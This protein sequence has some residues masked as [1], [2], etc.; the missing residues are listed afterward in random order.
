MKK[1]LSLCLALC[2]AFTLAA[3]ALA[4]TVLAEAPLTAAE[5]PLPAGAPADDGTACLPEQVGS[6]K[7][8]QLEAVYLNGY[9]GSDSKD[10]TTAAQAVRTLDKALSLLA[11]NGTVYICGTVGL[12]A[13]KTL[14]NIRFARESTYKGSLFSVAGKGSVL[15]LN[16]V[17][18]DG[19]NVQGVTDSLVSVT[20]YGTL[21]VNEGTKLINNYSTGDGGA[22]YAYQG[23]LSLNGGEISNN[24]TD[25]AGGG[26]GAIDST[27][28][29]TGT[30]ITGNTSARRGGGVY[31]EKYSPTAQ[32]VFTISAGEISGNRLT[33]EGYDGAGICIWKD[34]EVRISGGTIKDNTSVDEADAA[35]T[36][37]SLNGG[38]TSFATLKLSGSPVI[39]GDVCLWDEKTAGPVI[40]VDGTFVPANPV[41]V[42]ANWWS[43]GTV[44]A[45]YDAGSTPDPA[46]FEPMDEEYGL[47]VDGQTL[48]WVEK[49]RVVFK[50]A[51][52]RTTYKRLYVMPNTLVDKSEAPQPDAQPG[53]YLMGWVRYGAQTLWD[54]DKNP[55]VDKSTSLLAA[56]GIK[57]PE[58][59]I[60]KADSTT[61]YEGGSVVLT[62]SATQENPHATF[63][64][65]WYQDGQQIP[66]ADGQ[67]L[68][69]TEPGSYMVKVQAMLN[70]RL[71]EQ[72]E[73]NT[74]VVAMG[75]PPVADTAVTLDKTFLS[76]EPGD[77]AKLKAALTPAD[78]TYKY[79]F[80]ESSDEAIA[81]VSDSGLVTAVADG[82]ATITAKSWYGNT[83][84]CEVTVKKADVPTP[85]EP[86]DP[87]PT[88][89]LEGFV[90]RC[91]RVA[92]SRD[93]DKAGHADWVRWLQDGTVDATS[94]T[95]G[96]VF[97]KEMNNKN[98]S[99]EDFVKTLYRLF[100][101]R[102]GEATGV[103]FWTKY[104]KDGHSRLEVFY[105]FADSIEFACIKANYGIQ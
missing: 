90:T 54:F 43:E 81:T 34:C 28:T 86:T 99:D 3:P 85:P 39:E 59:V 41:Q 103:A 77:T 29:L 31:V 100:M 72:V 17:T 12:T 44:A 91:Y 9:A 87:W 102:E 96:F 94:C 104:L 7:Q 38:G 25:R 11:E 88:E 8:A 62:A 42:C 30:K 73:S 52:N 55:I 60:L 21:A 47:A 71:S 58:S 36:A 22:V 5:A 64:Y 61:L 49:H 66:D 18:V 95:Y 1:F 13:S 98:L 35:G 6:M 48:K 20:N 70:G 83:A 56:W 46:H 68:T 26:I 16:N 53:F 2:M 50:S 89:G 65:T 82:T 24:G 57:P 37:I 76:L 4:E 40:L 27:V 79:I 75:Q 51:D 19:A 10:G 105:G 67:T 15:T 97:S 101:D 14:E 92:L 93:P 23:T 84:T 78:A 80:W 69:V 33:K 32:S 45:Q 74:V 63:S